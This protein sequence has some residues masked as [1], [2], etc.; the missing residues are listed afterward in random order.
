MSNDSRSSSKEDLQQLLNELERR[1]AHIEGQRDAWKAMA[2]KLM[3]DAQK[4]RQAP[5][6]PKIEPT[7]YNAFTS[8]SFKMH[9]A[10]QMLL[11]GASNR[12]IAERFQVAEPTAKVYVRQIA[13]KFG[14]KKRPEI[15]R[16]A[17]PIFQTISSDEYLLIAGL[18]KTWDARWDGT[19]TY[20][21]RIR[22]KTR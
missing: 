10:L 17:S 4:A 1:I 18:P 12:E 13:A 6:A 9:A 14:V 15:I 7:A 16:K 19:D 11:R 2:E 21:A 22:T 8:L 20:T 3:H 5:P